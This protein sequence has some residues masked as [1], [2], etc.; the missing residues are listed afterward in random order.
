VKSELSLSS[1]P[2]LGELHLRH[3]LYFNRTTPHLPPY[4]PVLQEVTVAAEV[5]GLPPP[6][7]NLVAPPHL[8]PSPW[9]A[10]SGEPRYPPP[11]PAVSPRCPGRGAE[12]LIDREAANALRGQRH[13]AHAHY[14]VTTSARRAAPRLVLLGRFGRWARPCPEGLGPVATHHCAGF[15]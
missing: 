9:T 4:T 15:F 7:K 3:L 12:D 2:H 14:V 11:C 8:H 6:L 13:R 5:T 10:R 1:F